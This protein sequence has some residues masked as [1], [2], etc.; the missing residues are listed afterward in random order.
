MEDFRRV[1]RG[2]DMYDVPDSPRE[3]EAP[4]PDVLPPN[5]TT[6][7]GRTAD[8]YDVPDSPRESE[9]PSSNRPIHPLPINLIRHLPVVSSHADQ[10]RTIL[11]ELQGEESYVAHRVDTVRAEVEKMEKQL[12]ALRA[13]AIIRQAMESDKKTRIIK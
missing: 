12:V 10:L 8:M 13:I 11:T 1:T 3:S 9:P 2:E 5:T 6:D 7:H 4:Q